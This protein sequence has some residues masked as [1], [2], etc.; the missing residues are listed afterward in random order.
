MLLRALLRVVVLALPAFEPSR[1]EAGP[2]AR[3][4]RFSA[5]AAATFN[6]R[7]TACHT[8]GKG[9]KVG[10]DLKGV[11]ERGERAWL[12][13]FVHASSAMIASGDPLATSLFAE[14]KQQ[15][16]PDWTDLSEQHINDILDYLAIGGPEIKPVDERSAER[17]SW[18][19]SCSTARCA[20]AMADSP[21][22][23]AMPLEA[24]GGS[25]V[26]ASAPT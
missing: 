2:E 15:R 1:A 17:R 24:R 23:P 5:E 25:W 19:A 4:A 18:V 11:T 26:A 22:A 13:R 20:S 16:M 21:V 12:L 14:F 9:I 7:C 3:A 10:P 8:Y 6:S